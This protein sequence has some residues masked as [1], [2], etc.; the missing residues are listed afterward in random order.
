MMSARGVL[1]NLV[2]QA[3]KMTQFMIRVSWGDQQAT[4]PKN[5]YQS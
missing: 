3:S 2:M 5:Y 1:E 4:V